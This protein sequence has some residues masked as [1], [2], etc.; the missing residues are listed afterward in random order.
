[1]PSAAVLDANVLFIR[2]GLVVPL[3]P[4]GTWDDMQVGRPS[5]LLDGATYKMWYFGCALAGG[6]SIGYATSTDGRSWMKAG[7]VLTPS[8]PAEGAQVMYPTVIKVGPWYRMWYNGW[9]GSA[10][11][12]LT[13]RSRDGIAW[14]KQGV[15]FGPGPSGSPD[16]FA[17]LFPNVLYDDHAYKMY[18]TGRSTDSDSSDVIMLATSHNG[19]RW[20]RVGVVLDRGPAG[21]NDST[22][23]AF[24]S[25]VRDGT[26]YEMAYMGR[27]SSWTTWVLT[28]TSQDG[29]MWQ[30]VG[31]A[32]AT[33]PPDENLIGQP[34]LLELANGS[35]YLYYNGRAGDMDLQVYLAIAQP[36]A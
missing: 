21:S 27:D 15:V 31:V 12:V 23:A 14:A 22:Q 20:N 8:L 33:L 6:C 5:V 32:L 36:P 10:W 13:A 19:L 34:C 28:A 29:R 25:V 17:A 16:Q 4:A 30:K 1:M 24:P 18:Y 35:I 7:P 2:Q 26:S 9:D 11:T 3:G